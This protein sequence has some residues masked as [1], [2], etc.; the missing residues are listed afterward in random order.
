MPPLISECY[1]KIG[2]VWFWRG[3]GSGLGA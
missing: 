1:A 2:I 3:V